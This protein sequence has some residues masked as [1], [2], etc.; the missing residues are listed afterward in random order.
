LPPVPMAL[1][2][3]PLRSRDI[4]TDPHF[5]R[6]LDDTPICDLSVR[7][8]ST[9]TIIRVPADT[10]YTSISMLRVHLLQS[11]KSP[12]S[13]LN[14]ADEETHLD[15]IHNF[16]ELAVLAGARWRLDKINPILPFHL[17]ALDVIDEALAGELPLD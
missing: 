13:S 12:L 1:S 5:V 3:V 16:H 2:P 6:D 9:A 15:I 11:I 4:W 14:A 17:A 8:L 10:D 7:A